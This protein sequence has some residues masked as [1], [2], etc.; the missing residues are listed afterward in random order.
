MLVENRLKEAIGRWD[1]D[2]KFSGVISVSRPNGVF[3]QKAFG[4][5]HRAEELVNN[6]ETAFAI[7]SGTKL[8]TA[9][10]VCKLIDEGKLT[11]ESR[12][13]DV[14]KHNL[15]SINEEITISHLLTHTS[16]V[17]D[18][19]DEEESD[20]YLDI[21]R[22]YESLP[23]H[24]WD[25]LTNYLSLFNELPQKFPPGER[26]GYS[27]AGYVLLGLVVE[28]VTNQNFQTYV[29]DNIISPLELVHTGFYRSN[30][31]PGNTAHGYHFN[32]TYDEYETNTL[33]MPILG[34]SDGG[35]FTCAADVVKVWQ[36]L[37]SNRIVS[38]ELTKQILTPHVLIGDDT[39]CG[40]GVFIWQH[41]DKKAFFSVGGDF[42]VDYFS[43][44]FPRNEVVA[45]ALGN[46]E[47]N[48]YSLFEEFFE[49]LG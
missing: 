15:K 13:Y 3:Y 6:P 20:D 4:F 29:R 24:K 30:N 40:Y 39:Y 49:I 31:L 23:V 12:I 44:Y 18:Y 21:L 45:S 32:K 42:G 8:F 48:T 22:L 2:E 38:A 16:G 7:A 19:I 26:F 1:A 27:N 11:P 10:A 9:L 37:I 36:G 41:G 28:G 34:G 14:I 35:I 43:A 25:S 17:G 5:R 33:Y 46:T 47:V